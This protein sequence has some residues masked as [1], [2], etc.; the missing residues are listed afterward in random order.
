MI[1][2]SPSTSGLPSATASILTPKGILQSGLFIKH[3]DQIVHI[4]IALHFNYNTDSFLGRLIGNVYDVTGLLCLHQIADI[5][6]KFTDSGSDHGVRDF[7]NDDLLP[8]AFYLFHIYFSTNLDLSGSSLIN[9]CQIIFIDDDPACREIRSFD[10]LHQLF[11]RDVIVLHVCLNRI[12]NLAQVMCRILVA[13]PTAI[14]S[15]PFSRRFGILTGRTAGSFSV[16][17]KFGSNQ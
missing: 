6:Q 15:A 3:V 5:V 7:G 16:S 12:H 4:C 11:C 2:L 10:V 8:S 9:F 13:I 1:R 14:P 17:S